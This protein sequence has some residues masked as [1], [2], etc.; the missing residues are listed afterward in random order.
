MIPDR[1]RLAAAD[2][3][4]LLARA[5]TVHLATVDASGAP[6]VRALHV[7]LVDGELVWHGSQAGEKAIM[8]GRP[9]QI[10][11]HE[12]VAEIPSHFIDPERACPATTYYESVHA[13]GVPVE[14]S[15]PA[16]KARL[17]QALM[18]KYQPEG[19][20]RPLAGAA[21][22]DAAAEFYRA[23]VAG[24][25]V[26]RMALASLTGKSKLGQNRSPEQRRHILERLWER[27]RP[28]DLAA[29]DRI[30]AANADTPL[31]AFLGAPAGVR[32]RCAPAPAQALAAAAL[33]AGRYWTQGESPAALAAAHRD[34]PGW[35]GA[36]DA[37]SGELIGSG[38]VLGDGLRTAWILDLIVR[39]DR[40]GRGVGSALL[41]LL[42]DHPLARG[43][44]AIRLRTRDAEA[45]Y[46]PFGFAP[47]AAEAWPTLE[48]ERLRRSER[49]D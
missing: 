7:V 5:E 8:A 35:L 18:E 47:L 30:L 45:F 38:R 22:A 33:L 4:A 37:A 16:E 12:R 34:S 9:V 26:L 17:L 14:V 48:R 41:R 25:R 40:Q 27:G 31:P 19:G 28:A 11:A 36:E 21:D 46:R 43:A 3:L 49:Q 15:D 39:E 24:T 42:L 20:H 13:T 32:L 10:A 29:I 1:H 2:A 6:L 23:S 44:R